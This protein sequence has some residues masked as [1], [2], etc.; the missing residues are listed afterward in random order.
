M[1][2]LFLQKGWEKARAS[3]EGRGDSRPH[4][5]FSTRSISELLPERQAAPMSRD[6]AG[7]AEFQ[8]H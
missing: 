2:Y 8:V 4:L 6:T 3:P 1:L 5:L 7:K